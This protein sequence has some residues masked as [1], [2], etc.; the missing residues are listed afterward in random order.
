MRTALSFTV[1]SIIFCNQC[2]AGNSI[3]PGNKYI[4]IQPVYLMAVYDS[5]NNRV[6]SKETA[7]AY[8][9]SQEYYNKAEVAFQHKV[10]TGTTITIISH[11][12]KIWYLPWSTE[13]YF[14]S[15]DPDIS[16]GLD[17]EL[18]LNRGIEGSL[19]GLNSQLFKRP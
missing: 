1:L 14:I 12:P 7:R 18:A 19:D 8:L 2:Y 15:L 17:V 16:D 13:R 4:T 11:A 6:V 5:L 9:H 3:L 10:K